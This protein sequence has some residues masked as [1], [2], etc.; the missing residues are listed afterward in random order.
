MIALQTTPLC[1]DALL[2]QTRFGAGGTTA[3]YQPG[4]LPLDVETL[5]VSDVHLGIKASRPE[6]LLH[7]LQS[8]RF[9]RLILLGDILHDHNVRRFCEK[10][11]ELLAFIAA[12]SHDRRKEVI[13]L[14]GNHDRHLAPLIAKLTGIQ[15]RESFQWSA[16]NQRFIATHGD[17]FDHFL[18]RNEK[19]ARWVTHFYTSC[20][21]IFSSDGHWPTKL[22]KLHVGLSGLSD[23]IADGAAEFAD[24]LGADVIVCGHT[25][26]PLHRTYPRV[27]GAEGERLV[28][29]Y[30]TGSWVQKPASFVSVSGPD[31]VQ[32]VCP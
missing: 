7:T 29:Y 28:R 31:V 5:I 4:G 6:S 15:A 25:H 16:D 10:S 18:W 20:Q 8:W 21:N 26:E 12:L 17:R 19:F 24:R 27:T 30:N 3:W 9:E 32:H 23:K 13:W 1:C 14:Y 22:A 2:P 11:W